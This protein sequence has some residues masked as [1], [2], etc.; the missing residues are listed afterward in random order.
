MTRKERDA[1]RLAARRALV[2]RVLEKAAA[3][4]ARCPSDRDIAPII[5]FTC[6]TTAGKFL[7]AMAAEGLIAIRSSGGKRQVTIGG[8]STAPFG[9][10]LK[11][12][13]PKPPMPI[14]AIID[15]AA[16]LF[17]VRPADIYG[18]SQFW[19]HVRPRSAV[20][21]VAWLHGWSSPAIGAELARDHSTILNAR[22]RALAYAAQCSLTAAR[23][24]RLEAIAESY[25]Q[26]TGDELNKRP[27]LAA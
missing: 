13:R 21:R 6:K 24:R 17:G 3:T 11:P 9:N 15:E 4:G 19:R 5:G 8:K 12:V 23:L 2:M 18:P 14:R 22:D 20:C 27:A 25:N 10:K 26:G 16:T 1:R 7:T